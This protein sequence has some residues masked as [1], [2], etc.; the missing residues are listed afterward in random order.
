MSPPPNHDNQLSENRRVMLSARTENYKAPRLKAMDNKLKNL[1][2]QKKNRLMN[3]VSFK[4][5]LDMILY[6]LKLL[7]LIL[8]YSGAKV[9]R[10]IAS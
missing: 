10:V 2:T 5:I 8:T 9:A 3:R 6:N 7:E 4:I 1:I